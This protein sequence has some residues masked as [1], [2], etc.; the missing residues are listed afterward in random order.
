MRDMY[1]SHKSD[2]TEFVKKLN[3]LLSMIVTKAASTICDDSQNIQLAD[4]VRSFN[5]NDMVELVAELGDES[6]KDYVRF[7]RKKDL[8]EDF[9]N[10]FSPHIDNWH[11]LEGFRMRDIMF[12]SY[13][14]CNIDCMKPLVTAIKSYF[15]QAPPL[16]YF[17]ENLE[18]S[19]SIR[20]EILEARSI[21]KVAILLTSNNYFASEPVM[22]LEYPYFIEQ[23]N[24][25]NLRILWIPCEPSSADLHGLGDVWTPAG[26][27]PLSGKSDHGRKTALDLAARKIYEYF[28]PNGTGAS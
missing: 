2:A 13:C 6:A 20:Q 23:R 11:K 19:D 16:W 3:E 18:F 1:A 9:K 7:K 22:E 27:E 21:T 26:I 24:L 28:N 14:K 10:V 8:S 12:I 4:A 25:E 17:E 15:G 5:D